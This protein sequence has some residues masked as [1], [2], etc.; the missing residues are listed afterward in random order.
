[1]GWEEWEPKAIHC[2]IKCVF[3]DEHP[4]QRVCVCLC[5]CE[6]LNS[7]TAYRESHSC[8]VSTLCCAL[9]YAW[10]QTPRHTDT[11]THPTKCFGLQVN[12]VCRSAS[13]PRRQIIRDGGNGAGELRVLLYIKDKV[14]KVGF[15]PSFC[16]TR[17]AF[18][19][20]TRC[21]KGKLSVYLAYTK[22]CSG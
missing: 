10:S 19:T 21:R 3:V 16:G 7:R 1:M 20:S 6:P 22:T 12:C 2:R 9:L 15:I 11:H 8:C 4:G 14:I 17:H 5:V 18:C 13:T